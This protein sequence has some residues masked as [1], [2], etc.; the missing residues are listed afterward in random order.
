MKIILPFTL[1]INFYLFIFSLFLS[2]SNG[3]SQDQ[4]INIRGNAITILNNDTNPSL[5]DNTDFG[6]SSLGVNVVKTF[7]IQNTYPNGNPNKNELTINSI[8]VSGTNAG[9]FLINSSITT[10]SRNNSSTFTITFRPSAAGL[11]TARVTISSNDPDENPYIYTIQ[12]TGVLPTPEINITGKGNSIASGDGSPSTTDGTNFGTI[13]TGTSFNQQFIIQNTVGNTTLAL[14]GSPIVNI[15]GDSEFSIAVQPAS[16][17]INGVNSLNFSV[18]YNPL[19]DG[20][21]AA[22]ISIDNNDSNENP[23]TFTVQGTSVSPA[24]EI[25]VTGNGSS[26]AD[27]DLYPSTF[28]N[29]NFGSV[30]IGNTSTKVYNIHNTGVSPLSIS[31][32]SLSN[33]TDFQ[34]VGTPY[35][36]S[37]SPGG[38]TQF[39]IRYTGTSGKH[40]STVTIESDDSDEG[41][42]TF[43]IRGSSKATG[44]TGLWTVTNITANSQLNNPY[45]IT[46]F[47]DGYLWVTERTSKKIVRVNSVGTGNTK[48][49][50]INLSGSVYQTGGQ[51]GLMG[52][53]IHPD[54]MANP[55]TAT[56]NYVYVA[57]TFSSNGA[58]SGRKLRIARL[59]YSNTTKTLAVDTSLDT[60]GKIIEIP[61]A[62]ND[63]NSGRL[64][65]G[66]DLKL[67]YTIGDQGANQFG[68][69]CN[70]IE[71]Q[72]LPASPSDYSV[73]KGKVLRLNLDGTVPS[74]NPSLNGV[75]SHVYTYGHRNT[76]GIIFGSNGKLYASEHGAKV[77]DELNIITAGKNYGWPH[78][79]GYYDNLAYSYCNWS[80]TP[81]GCSSGGFTDHNCPSGVTSVNEFNPVNNS[82]LSN[83]QPPIGTYDS[84]TNYDPSGGWLTWPTVAPSSIDIYEGGLIPNWGSSLLI[85]TLKEGTIFRAKLNASG[86]A[87]MDITTDNK[88]EEFHSSNDRYRDL[89]MD[90]DG[91]TFYAITDS[92]GTTSGPS[93]SSSVTLS[94]PG[95]IMKF[96]YVGATGTTYYVDADG[97]GFGD[98]NDT[99]GS[100]FPSDPG[101]GYSLTNDDCDDNQPLVYPGNTE[102]LYDGIDNDCDPLTLDTVD[103]D[104]DGVNSDTDCDDNQPLA[105]PGNTEILYDGIDND[106]DP[107]TLDTV[108]A[109]GD[110]VNS[111]ID[112]DDNQ[113]LAYPGNTEVLYDG[114][115]ND[116]DPLTLDYEDSDG[117]GVIDSEDQCPGFDDAIDIDADGIPDGC[118][119]LI[120]SDNDGVADAEDQCPGFDDTADTD[121]DGVAD[122]CDICQGYDDTIDAD[123]DGTPDGC[124][125]LVDSDNDGVADSEDQCP[126]FDDN[127]DVDGDSIPDGCD[128]LIDSDNDGVADSVDQCPGF[129][130]NLDADGDGIP[131]G[132]DTTCEDLITPFNENPLTHSGSGSNTTILDLTGISEDI[133]FGIS[134]LSSVTNGKPSDRYIDL[135]TVSYIDG[136]DV[137]QLYG[138]FDGTN[139]S[140]VNVVQAGV[141]KRIIVSLSDGLNGNT[142][143]NMS[144]NLSA[145][146]YCST[147]VF[148]KIAVNKKAINGA[149]AEPIKIYPNP[150]SSNL[151]ITRDGFNSSSD[152]KL[153][154]VTGQLVRH[155]ILKTNLSKIDI[156][157]LSEG[158]YLVRISNEKGEPIKTDRIIIKVD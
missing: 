29:T 127:V 126:G 120:D 141:V 154:T 145:V 148:S 47:T 100:Q 71:S 93:G 115:D 138:V 58:D 116:C 16:N 135:V 41:T 92:Q 59:L 117:D 156:D 89:A 17:S 91:L 73:Y 37:V 5:S 119:P 83:F 133:S 90:P 121:A 48:T 146:S 42:Y 137:T 54:L 123:A 106:C 87:L 9:E 98:I 122:G 10:I 13:A 40:S 104:G 96:T 7:E 105:Y 30:N 39:S 111:D 62:S 32:I 153:Y 4:D 81:G 124:D 26:I 38:N 99:T 61:H 6:S 80:S 142:N 76:Q 151:F 56:N 57:Y 72:S 75:K 20:T 125:S 77:D 101:N 74:D 27:G 12:G 129:D 3:Y 130:D 88:F 128:P 139:V 22:I 60:N 118:D 131:D 50:M 158:L 134:G 70:P 69:A 66:P 85:T 82:L 132:C 150:A 109:D 19:T 35:S 143:S 46:Y 21:H 97:D 44:D 51:D 63:H 2:F 84:T 1:K 15:T 52:M 149:I 43:V 64:I 8:S 45:E 11:R 25:N 36:A 147:N 68:N 55:G 28:N 53:A 140:S 33:T 34:I 78:I 102:I 49:D 114:I 94:N 86:D 31:D 113:P 136:N 18:E 65:I 95:V 107:L 103:A 108:D 144:I 79:A 152:L 155:I 67:Y 23:Y 157:G 24:P 110:G 14:T 112:C